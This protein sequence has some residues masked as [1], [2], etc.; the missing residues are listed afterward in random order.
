[1]STLSSKS[2]SA[3]QTNTFVVGGQRSSVSSLG[4]THFLTVSVYFLSESE[5]IRMGEGVAAT[6][7]AKAKSLAGGFINPGIDILKSWQ[8]IVE[9]CLRGAIIVSDRASYI[10]ASQ[11]LVV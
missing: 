4:P 11:R 2:R 8:G 10:L 3:R 1:M 6:A 7:G 9:I 5:V